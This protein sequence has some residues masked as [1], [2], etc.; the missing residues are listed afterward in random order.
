MQQPHLVVDG[1]RVDLECLCLG[2]GE[3][4]FKRVVCCDQFVRRQIGCKGATGVVEQDEVGHPRFNHILSGSVVGP[5]HPLEHVAEFLPIRQTTICP[6][7]S[8]G[9]SDVI[10][11]ADV[12][13]CRGAAAHN[14]VKRVG[15]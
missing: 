12:E 7:L 13:C 5:G 8:C 15:G 1:N 2:V 9:G 3:C 4:E 11:N 14:V 10:G 6:W